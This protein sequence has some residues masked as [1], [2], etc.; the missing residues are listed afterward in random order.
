MRSKLP[1]RST[2]N[3]EVSNISA[4]GIW[5]WVRGEE[6]LLPYDGFPWFRKARVE[7]I[8]NVRLLHS[9]HLYW[10]DL[11]V[12]LELESLS[13]PENYPLVYEV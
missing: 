1:G 4:H 5:L 3:V 8:Q 11:D 7:E 12:D 6:Y 9:E 10:P 13:K 2:S